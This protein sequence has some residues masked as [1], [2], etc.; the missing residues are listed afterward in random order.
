[1]DT[2][3]PSVSIA[4]TGTCPPL[5][6][7]APPPPPEP[8]TP[9]ELRAL[10]HGGLTDSD[11][12]ERLLAQVARIEGAL[13]LE[14]GDGLA[15][16]CLGDRLISLGFSNLGDYAREILDIRERTAQA[17]A[18]LSRELRSRP[19]LRAAVRTGEVRPRNAQTVLPVA[20]GDAEAEW[21]ERAG[22]ETVRA[23]EK[24]V[25]AVR[26][27]GEDDDEWTRFRVRLSPEDRATVD[28]ALVIAARLMPGSKRPQ[29]LEAIAQEYLAEHPT[30]A[31]DD[32][33]G[34]VGGGFRPESDRLERRKAELEIETDGWSFLPPVHRVEALD[35]GCGGFEDMTSAAAIDVRLRDLAA[36]RARWDALLG[37]C[38]YA[39]KRT[40][41]WRIAGFASFEHYCSERLGLSARTVEQ[42]AALEKRLWEVP[43]LRAARDGGLSYEKLRLLS[44]LPNHE[45]EPW[46]RRARQLTCVA[47]EAELEGRDEAQMRAARVLRARVPVR[48]ALLLQ[49]AI[50]SARA[51]EGRLLPDGKCLVRV[52]RHFTE[53]WKPYVKKARTLSQKVRDRDLGRCR[54]PGCSRRAVHA[55]HVELRSRGG[56]DST[57]NLV[58]L[59]ACHH[60]RGIHGGYIRVWGRAPDQLVWEVRGSVWRD[61]DF[62]MAAAEAR[63]A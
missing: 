39:V 31:G 34:A 40:G 15:A 48:I 6:L 54:V 62:G 19:L 55:H 51:A 17:M 38:S 53:T 12:C 37:Y 52:A 9:A 61:G 58:A 10:V 50:R 56:A 3:F 14:I 13:D 23:L 36:R 45:V 18:H 57:E 28:E 5:A 29:Q 49:A 63:A 8:C 35:A 27:G 26:A 43:A 60:L 21:V 20:I 41:L 11:V 30:E 25:R 42:R 44:R 7:R 1:V 32:G 22:L 59:C 2:G 4:R 47:L 46:V 33:G 16:L 24:A